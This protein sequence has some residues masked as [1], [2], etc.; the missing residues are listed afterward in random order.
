MKLGKGV[1]RAAVRRALT[2]HPATFTYTGVLRKTHI[3]EA[4]AGIRA[5]GSPRWALPLLAWI[6]SHPNSPRD[7]VEDLYRHAGREVLMSLAMN[8]GLPTEMKKALLDHAD[9]EVRDHANHFFSRT[10]RH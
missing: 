2:R 4:L 8:P 6:A 5:A 3:R 1:G 7:V 9:P 10:K